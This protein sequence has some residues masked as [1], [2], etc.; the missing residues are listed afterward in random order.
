[1]TAHFAYENIAHIPPPPEPVDPVVPVPVPPF[2]L[3]GGPRPRARPRPLH[4]GVRLGRPVRCLQ[5]RPD[6]AAAVWDEQGRCWTGQGRAGSS[7][8]GPQGTRTPRPPPPAAVLLLGASSAL[9]PL[10]L[11]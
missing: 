6:R 11:F 8:G 9:S 2:A 4:P 3:P 7:T 10:Y 1:M 5:V